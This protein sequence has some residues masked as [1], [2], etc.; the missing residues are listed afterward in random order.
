M[1]TTV[2]HSDW[3]G[4]VQDDTRSYTL[5]RAR[6][7]NSNYPFLSQW[8]QGTRILKE[9][10]EGDLVTCGILGFEL[11][12]KGMA[13]CV[14]SFPVIGF[15]TDNQVPWILITGPAFYACGHS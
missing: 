13:H 4:P 10:K 7:F 15:C 11:Q 8:S 6:V 5:A 14:L 12:L 3:V 2:A 1:P 9:E